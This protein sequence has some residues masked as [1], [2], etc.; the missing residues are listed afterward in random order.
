MPDESAYDYRKEEK[1]V[2]GHSD[3]HELY[4]SLYP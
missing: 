3:E 2:I 4:I 1:G